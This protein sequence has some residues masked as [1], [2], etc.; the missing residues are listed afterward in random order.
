MRFFARNTVRLRRNKGFDLN[1]DRAGTPRVN[2]KKFTTNGSNR[3]KLMKL[4]SE[5]AMKLCKG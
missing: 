2:Y 1:G 3:S 4:A 5:N